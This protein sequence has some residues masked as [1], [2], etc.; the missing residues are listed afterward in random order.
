MQTEQPVA[1]LKAQFAAQLAAAGWG[2]T[3][4]AGD[5]V[6]AWSAWEVPDQEEN[7]RGLLLVLAP[8]GPTERSLTLRLEKNE[9]PD[10]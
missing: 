10:R 3:A 1:A 6:V 4:G 8:F 2:R 5:D 9:E 7:W